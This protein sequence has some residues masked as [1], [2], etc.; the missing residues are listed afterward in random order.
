MLR[1]LA[2]GYGLVHVL[3]PGRVV[4][5]AER[6][7][8]ENPDAGRLRPWTLPIAR[9]KGLAVGLLLGVTGGLPKALG[10]PMGLL[11]FMLV[12][13]PRR[14]LEYGLELAYENPGELE[15]KPWVTPATRV[16]GVAS[17]IAFLVTTTGDDAAAVDD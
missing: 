9:L 5:V 17:L 11:G 10:A 16:L 3:V 14:M 2:V 6:V 7:A 13:A 12:A 15:A 4:D 1:L 8:L